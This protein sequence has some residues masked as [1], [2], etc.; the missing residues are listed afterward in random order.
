MASPG[1]M[2]SGLSRELFEMWCTDSKN[3][4]IIAG[5]IKINNLYLNSKYFIYYNS[6]RLCGARNTS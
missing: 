2:E 3:G 4:V 5:K 1:V 6:F